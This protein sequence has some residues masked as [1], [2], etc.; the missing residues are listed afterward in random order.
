M[1]GKTAAIM[2]VSADTV[3]RYMR[4]HGVRRLIHGHTHR[5]A[6]HRL[7][8]DGAEAYRHVLADWSATSG[9]ALVSSDGQLVREPVRPLALNAAA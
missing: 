6:D 2:D 1:A 3:P 8:L 7:T 4:R 9:E 5:P